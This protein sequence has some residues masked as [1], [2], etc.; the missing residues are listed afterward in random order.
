MA[1][2]S[3][4]WTQPTGLT[5]LCALLELE[6]DC[7]VMLYVVQDIQP[8]LDELMRQWKELEETTA[9]KGEKLFDAN[10]HVLYEQSC[11]DIDGWINEIES[12]IITEDVGHDLTT[13]NLLV[14]KQN[15]RT[16]A[17]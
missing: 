4:V 1:Y 9:A 17:L 6:L 5:K 10:R 2:G 11:E 8:R 14:Q 16:W 12:Q 15:V 13:V 3:S 7:W